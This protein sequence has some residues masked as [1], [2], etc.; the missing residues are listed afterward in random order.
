[1]INYLFGGRRRN[2]PRPRDGVGASERGPRA[3]PT[4]L[5]EE[6]CSDAPVFRP[7]IQSERDC[8]ATSGRI[9]R[10]GNKGDAA[11]D[12]GWSHGRSVRNDRPL[13]LEADGAG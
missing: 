11:T 4:R 9:R 7:F 6:A 3:G 2:V 12:E 13:M 8:G 10:K 5:P 1:M